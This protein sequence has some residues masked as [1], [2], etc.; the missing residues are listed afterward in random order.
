MAESRVDSDRTISASA[1]SRDHAI[2]RALELTKRMVRWGSASRTAEEYQFSSRLH[3]LLGEIDDGLLERGLFPVPD[4]PWQRSVSWAFMRGEGTSTVI[5]MSHFDTVGTKDYGALQ[6]YAL[7]PDTLRTQMQ[8]VASQFDPGT[9]AHLASDDWLFGRGAADMK[10]GIAAHLVVLERLCRRV[11]SGSPLPGNVLFLCTPDEECESAG[12]LAA[13]EL[14][15]RMKQER[16]IKFIGAINNDYFAPRYEGDESKRVYTGTVGKLLAG[17]Y[18]RGVETHAGE[19]YDGCDA[20][21]LLAEIVQAV[22]MR[23]ELADADGD[24][25]APPPVMLKA[26][27]FKET[28]DVQVPFDAYG[29]V[30]FLTFT[31]SPEDVCDLLLAVVHDALSH[32]VA[33]VHGERIRWHER[34]GI[35][36]P[37][38]SA[39]PVTLAYEDLLRTARTCSGAEAVDH[40]LAVTNRSLQKNDADA[41]LRSA[42]IVRRL[43]DLSGLTGPA[44]VVYYSPPFYPQVSGDTSSGFVAAVDQAARAHGANVLRRYPYMS[45]ASYLS[46]QPIDHLAALK[47][48]M[49]L[50]RD[51]PDVTG[52]SLPLERIRELNVDVA[53]I[54]VWGHG[55]H[56][57]EERVN[58]PYSCGEVPAI[59]YD[60][61]LLALD[62]DA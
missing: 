24:E 44:A 50:W 46:A 40:A 47:S 3:A 34:A 19:P 38:D 1:P 49:P 57:R 32:S 56:T 29:Y 5:L 4:D 45:D 26:T 58:I 25:V 36:A 42:H 11:R 15:A 61:V 22:S 13:V 2:P 14:L 28:Y 21:L 12:I 51:E 60:A 62:A 23:A 53:N 31:L 33:R 30:N 7:D 20:D 16:N 9:Q 17:L 59:I 54:G 37:P 48:N 35:A 8:A 18:V 10:S 55:A 27:D 41:R 43:W 52:Y 6:Q 39:V